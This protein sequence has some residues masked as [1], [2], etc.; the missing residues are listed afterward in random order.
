MWRISNYLTRGGRACLQ[1][2]SLIE[3]AIVLIIVGIM[4]GYGLP[5]LTGLQQSTK[6][7][8]THKHQDHIIH[9]LASYALING[10]LPLPLETFSKGG[11]ILIGFIPHLE[12]GIS[13]DLAKDGFGNHMVYVVAK[14]MTRTKHLNT[15]VTEDFEDL[16]NDQDDDNRETITTQHSENIMAELGDEDNDIPPPQQNTPSNSSGNNQSVANNLLDNSRYLCKAS[17]PIILKNSDKENVYNEENPVPFLLIGFARPGLGP[18]R[19]KGIDRSD[20]SEPER[21]NL[22]SSSVFYVRPL[23]LKGET[24]FRQIIAHISRNHLMEFYT[25]KACKENAPISN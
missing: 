6:N 14:S 9:A 18:I 11:G 1:G 5:M 21:V 22:T 13:E 19:G 4:A 3:I 12:L 20:Y 23:N 10:K 25:D 8:V 16:V 2:Y 15:N 7:Q 24:I 17:S